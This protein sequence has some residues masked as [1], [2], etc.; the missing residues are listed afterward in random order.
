GWWHT[1]L[2]QLV[3]DLKAF[4][5]EKAGGLYSSGTS[6]KHGWG[7]VKRAEFARTI[8]ER[9]VSGA[10]AKRRWDDAIAAIAKSP[11]YASL[12]LTPQLGILPI[13]EAPDSPL[14]GF[15]HL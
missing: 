13:G 1:Q 12:A 5:D 4:A 7:I 14:W 9:S 10:E 8:G 15:G 3:W 6:K 2:A 11:K